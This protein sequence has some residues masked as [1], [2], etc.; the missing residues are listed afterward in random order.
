MSNQL[1]TLGELVKARR[2]LLS[3]TQEQVAE[4]SGDG[5]NR[6]IVAH[7][8]QGI[9][10]PKPEHLKRICDILGVPQNYWEQFTDQDSMLRF[11][12]EEGLT[13]LTGH[14]VSFD[15]HEEQMRSSI[16]SLIRDL[17]SKPVTRSQARDLFNSILIFYG[18]PQISQEFFERYFDPSAF[19]SA[20]DFHGAIV[21][22]QK[23]AIRL[24]STLYEA[25]HAM[26]ANKLSVVLEPL[27]E[28]QLNKYH[29]RAEWSVIEEI[30]D[31]KLADLGYISAARVRQES[32]ERLALQ[33]FILDLAEKLKKQGKAAL[34]SIPEKTKR[35][36][37]SLLRQFDSIFK[38][39]LF[40][41]LFS[42]DAD[43]LIREAQRLAP[44][45]QVEL[46]RMQETQDVALRNLGQYLSADHMDIYVATSM[47]SDADFVSVNQFVKGLFVHPKIRSLKLRYFNPTQSWI[48]DRIA[49]GLVEA[50]MLRRASLTIYM[51]QKTDTFG[52]DSEASVALGQG[53]P[54][55]VYVPKLALPGGI[56][57]TE[58]L[59]KNSRHE[60]IQ[61]LDSTEQKEI[62]DGIDDQ[63]IIS[64]ILTSKFSK[65]DDNEIAET[66]RRH[67]SDFDL[68]FE[69]E[70]ISDQKQKAD[71]RQW[72]DLTIKENKEN[73]TLLKKIRHDL[74]GILVANTVRF[75][76][77][78][79]LFREIHP[80]ALQVVLSTGV[81]NG[82]LVVRSVEQCA[83]V[84]ES[85]IKNHLA[86]NLEKDA[87]NYR[88][89]ELN[90]GST[91]R[92]IS[93]HRLLR[94]AFQAFYGFSNIS[95][96]VE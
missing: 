22:Y 42:P 12:F 87:H 11:S 95:Q 66:V 18:V 67:W 24:F 4:K 41:P 7:L 68:Y 5:V 47:R 19:N 36:M 46:A 50:L 1:F 58:S 65:L 52:K 25:Y 93:R 49:K 76:N 81:L 71:Y 78:A 10:I 2:N 94:H 74:V 83:T 90:T 59:S 48:D 73:T 88:L 21:V 77:R 9:R 20:E 26:N 44:K 57:D 64:K 60:L 3:L 34:D 40:S 30:E 82:I 43:E 80:L 79:K 75:E 17:F 91:I 35:R 37:D 55:I 86:L 54:V 14:S 89:V 51:A 84:L 56:L 45:T 70:R 13:E 96:H 85:I 62:D 15:G 8:E 28:I 69:T 23:D 16:E 31:S 53:K 29:E 27:K 63:A 38:H 61:L 92:V 32:Q 33:K 6:S 72:L 39:G